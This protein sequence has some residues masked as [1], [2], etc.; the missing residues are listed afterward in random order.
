LL[1]WSCCSHVA[2]KRS[3]GIQTG[4]TRRLGNV[5][6]SLH[7]LLPSLEISRGK[8]ISATFWLEQC[9]GTGSSESDPPFAAP[10]AQLIILIAL[11][12][13]ELRAK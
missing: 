4:L 1:R 13:K 5:L 3:I 8:W 6:K 9:C 2:P 7:F 10:L 12:F 11:P